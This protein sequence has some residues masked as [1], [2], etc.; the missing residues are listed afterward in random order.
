MIETHV[1]KILAKT[2]PNYHVVAERFAK[3]TFSVCTCAKCRNCLTGKTYGS[4]DKAGVTCR[5][6]KRI[7]DALH[8]VGRDAAGYSRV[9]AFGTCDAA[10]FTREDYSHFTL[11]AD[12][13][14]RPADGR[15]DIPP[16]K[17]VVASGPLIP[18]IGG[19][20]EEAD[21]GEIF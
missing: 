4:P 3:D 16:M 19:T 13:A 1:L 20:D 9:D 2:A 17:D 10:Q 15:L 8:N 14:F 21:G 7:M 6:C 18:D 12:A 5:N 11:E